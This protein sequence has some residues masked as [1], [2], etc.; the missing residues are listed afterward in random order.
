VGGEKKKRWSK[1]SKGVERFCGVKKTKGDTTN[2]VK[3]STGMAVGTR[4]N[5][6]AEEGGSLV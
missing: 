1:V 4:S 5:G 3:K 2:E 6:C